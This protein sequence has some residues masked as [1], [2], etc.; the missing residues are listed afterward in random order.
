MADTEKKKNNLLKKKLIAYV[1]TVLITLAV[2][3]TLL[4]WMQTRG[5][6]EYQKNMSLV[7]LL[8]EVADELDSHTE[9]VESLTRR[10]HSSNQTTVRLIGLFMQSGAFKELQDATDAISAAEALRSLSV[11]TGL[12]SLMIVDTAGNMILMDN[13]DL[14]RTYGDNIQ[15][16]MIKSRENPSG[17]F[18]IIQFDR[19]TASVDGWE[20]TYKLHADG[21]AE[22]KPIKSAIVTETQTYNGYYYSTP[23][24]NEDGTSSGYWLV[25]MADATQMEAD[26]AGLTNMGDVLESLGVGKTG[27]VFSLDPKTGDFTY[28]RDTDGLVLTGKD[29]RQSGLTDDILKDGYAGIQEICG[30]Q[31]YCVTKIYS[32]EVFGDRVVIAATLPESELYGSKVYNIFWS[33]L[34]LIVVGNLILIYAIIIQMDQIRKGTVLEARKRLYTTKKGKTVYYNKALGLRIFPLLFIGLAAILGISMYTQ[35]LSQ[36]SSAVRISES[37]ID[38]IGI[39]VEKNVKRSDTVAEFYNKQNLYKALLLADIIKRAP[40]VV[41]DYN[42]NDAVHFEYAKNPDNSIVTD[43]YGNPVMTSRYQ[44]NLQALAKAYDFETMYVFNDRGRVIATSTQWWN[45]ELSEDPEA[46]SYAFR[47]VLVNSDYLVQDL[48][49]SDVGENEQFIGCAY[50]YYTYND[51]GTTRFA[52]EYE[53][54]HGVPGEDGTVAVSPSEITRHR[55]LLQI[56]IATRSIEDYLSMSTVEYTINGMNMFYEGYFVAF[57]DDEAHD[58]LYSPFGEGVAIQTKDSMFSGSFNGFITINGQ[59]FFSCIRKAGGIYIGTLIPTSTLFMLRNRV[60]TATVIIALVS[61]LN[62][63]GFMLYSNSDEDEAIRERLA[64]YE[65]E[66]NEEAEGTLEGSA[67]FD[68]TMPDGEKKRVRSVQS[69]WSKRFTEWEKKS[70]EQKFSSVVAGCSFLLFLFVLIS[71]LFAKTVFPED[72]IM[73]YIINGNLERSLNLFV[74]T[75][76]SMLLIVVLFGAKILQ[77]VIN[78]M[79]SNLGAR[80][81]TIGHLLESVIKYGGVIG[82]MFYSLFLMG[83]NTASLLTSAGILSIVVGLGAQSLISD[84]LAGIFIVF[85]GEFRVGDIVT[86]ADFRG[87]VIEIGIRTTKIEDFLGNI[88][89]YNN[90]E[91]SGVL[92]MTKEYSTVPITLAI[93]YGESLERV[94]AVLKDEFPEIRKK[95]KTIVSG[96]FYKGVSSLSDNA[97]NLLVVAQ[98]VEGD[99]AQLVRDLNRELYLA[100][101]RHGIN[102]PFPQVTVSYLKDEQEKKLSMREKKEV[103]EFV[104][105]QKEVSA[106]VD[107][108]RK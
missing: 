44:P 39:S 16:N 102:V 2:M 63:L 92:N 106:G 46:Q 8:N 80:A 97:V 52:S 9:S 107:I 26:I 23:V 5:Q 50:Y 43:Q 86:V 35:T 91:I 78:V 76:S 100:F 73:H 17:A 69:R 62:L 40:E 98:C 96:P 70:V 84:I 51:N 15:Y 45:F 1:I 36:L 34:A 55:G 72:S 79:T 13:A 74:V 28:Y 25:A 85:E 54:K 14:Y 56:S 31:Y 61:F 3:F 82:V 33:L 64:Q 75:R 38:E 65:E 27:F 95:I 90:S 88:K 83:L 59:K 67:N 71:V 58:V 21:T 4:S 20:G 60:S 105:E 101:N 66:E 93:E 7:P 87:T 104:E 18:S 37:R 41:F 77:K 99:R 22:Y 47:D 32:S 24:L 10:F 30:T 48:Q 12:Y 42:M 49:T 6:A 53:Y 108:D 103:E 11:N 19:I 68:V 94:E 89:I 57:S 81:E 29:F